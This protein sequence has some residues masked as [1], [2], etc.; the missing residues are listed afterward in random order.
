M[1]RGKI[2][3]LVGILPLII[4]VP[5]FANVFGEISTLLS[6]A[7]SPYSLDNPYNSNTNFL[8]KAV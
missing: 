1:L 3:G 7:K 2:N 4:K 8:E 6:I 5:V